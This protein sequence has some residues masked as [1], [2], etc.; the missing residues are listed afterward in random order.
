MKK[1][2]EKIYEKRNIICGII[3]AIIIILFG[4]SVAPKTLQ[5]YTYY[6]VSIGNLIM[7]N[8]IDMKD[9]YSWHEDLPYTYPHWMYDVFMSIIYNMGSWQG[10]YISVCIMSIILGLSIYIVNKKLNKNQVISFALTIGAMYL[11]KDYIAARAQLVTFIIFIWVIYFI[12]KFIE[13]PKKVGYAIGI[14]LASI[15]I[16]N[17]HVAVWPFLFVIFLPYIAEYIIC[18]VADTVIY[19]K[20]TILW[21]KILLNK[22]KNDE[23]KKQKINQELNEI[24]LQ[25]EKVKN[26]R[27]KEEPYKIRMKLN[28]NVKWL[29][30]VMAIC[31]LTGFLTP[32][33]TTPYTYLVKTME[34][35]TVNNINEH[36]PLTLINNIP[37]MCT[38]IIVLSLLIFTKVKI[39]LSD[40]FMIGGL[41]FLMF[42]SR[43]QS[44]M[45]VLIGSIIL[46]RMFTEAIKIYSKENMEWM[47]KNIVCILGIAVSVVAIFQGAKFIDKKKD[48]SYVNEASYP[49]DAANWIL[50]NFDVN[51]IKLFNEYNYGS[52]LLY[53]GIPVFIDSRADLYAPEFNGKKD[54]FMDF[55]NTSNLGKFY[56]KTFEEYGI[57][58]VI[59]YKNA[60]IRMIIDE[61]EP[62]KYNKIY[63][64]KYFVIYE[65]VK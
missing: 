23:T 46:N 42:S 53:R 5:N 13:N 43:R 54:I 3:F 65:V 30:L 7:E 8:G 62:E 47:F 50:E 39:R 55:I 6:T 36:L 63:S 61:T 59:L 40:L 17:I 58:H 18:L 51:N 26:V 15:I 14:I 41:T 4:F 52:Y 56:G 33:G 16:A 29:I 24:Y 34:G 2:L 27:E 45:F 25:N 22:Y 48:N 44:T 20:I 19:Q 38:I 60:K 9:H 21:K 35:N 10:I 32:L 1:I 64:D 57:T 12:E 49:V 28:K 11:L 37:I 31:G